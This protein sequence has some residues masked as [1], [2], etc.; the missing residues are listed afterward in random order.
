MEGIGQGPHPFGMAKKVQTRFKAPKGLPL[1]KAWRSYRKLTQEQLAEQAGMSPG[2]ISQLE[3]G[4]IRY[5]QDGLEA[6]AEAL[7]CRP[8]ELLSVDPTKEDA[9]WSLWERATA[10]EKVQ[11]VSVTQAL[12]KRA[13]GG[14]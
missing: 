14:S 5:S 3:K 9:I 4:L 6:L 13:S 12:T 8:G 1:L 2:N 11:I 10:A 7:N